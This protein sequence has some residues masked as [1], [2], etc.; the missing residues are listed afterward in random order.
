MNISNY[1]CWVLGEH[2]DDVRRLSKASI[3]RAKTF[4]IG[5]HLPVILWALSGYF[6]GA[7]L[8]RLGVPMSLGIG[9]TCAV[10]I[11]LVE[12]IVIGTPR[13]G[14]TSGFRIALGVVTALLGTFMVDLVLFDR[15][16]AEQ[17]AGSGEIRIAQEY[18]ARI[19]TETEIAPARDQQRMSVNVASPLSTG[20]TDG[21]SPRPS[22]RGAEGRRCRP[23]GTAGCDCPKG[24]SRRERSAAV[25]PLEP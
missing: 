2:P 22:A 13:N 23:D 16:I 25:R 18:A 7:S 24:S 12:R 20:G 4:A 9:L 1:L 11:Y 10:I 14:W 6:V 8:F 5:I 19:A 17:L 15:E 21:C 3:A